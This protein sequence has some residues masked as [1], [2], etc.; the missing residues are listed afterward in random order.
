MN[1]TFDVIAIQTAYLWT[2]SARYGSENKAIDSLLNRKGIGN[3]SIEEAKKGIQLGIMILDK[4]EEL[5]KKEK[6]ELGKE[7]WIYFSESEIDQLCIR[8]AKDLEELF[9]ERTSMISY[10]IQML[11]L[12]PWMR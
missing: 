11:V 4:T 7:N 12:Q 2:R 6:Q 5:A 3:V 8:M 9:P 10:A 1:D